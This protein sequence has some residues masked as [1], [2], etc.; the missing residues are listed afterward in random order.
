MDIT[1]NNKKYKIQ[2]NKKWN[3]FQFCNSLKIKIPVFCY[4][5]SLN[6]AGNCRMCLIEIEK[7]PKPIVACATPLV[8]N[9]NIYT[10]SPLVKK[11][12]EN[13]L[14]LL[15]VNHP[16]DCP[17][18][19]QGGECDLQENVKDFG[20]DRNRNFLYKR[21]SV[22][23]KN[24]GLIIKTIM[25][26]CIHCT[27]CV[28]FI[29]EYTNDDSMKVLGRGTNTEIGT[30]IN[31]FIKTEFSGNL[32]D[33]CPVGALTS[34]NYAFIARPWELKK[35][36]TIDYSD[37]LNTSINVFTKGIS[38]P[39]NHKKKKPHYFEHDKI[40]RILPTFNFNLNNNWI[41][42]KTRFSFDGL[43]SNRCIKPLLIN[44]KYNNKN[45]KKKSKFFQ[46]NYFLLN[47][48]IKKQYNYNSIIF[49]NNLKK[50]KYW[51]KNE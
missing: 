37:S 45:I 7:S 15:L 41:S 5:E 27:R 38:V 23:D 14:E 36:K 33:L 46:W 25:T 2:K 35:T 39:L 12:R 32:I 18:C 47:I 24:L 26:R 29:N 3:I 42:D 16:L 48:K 9:M 51:F 10:N 13:V 8:N 40:V 43:Y 31:K 50:N 19:D 17:I 49:L 30:Y 1:I 4:H 34:K 28:R 22:E 11:S 44:N 21:R 6:V 20:I